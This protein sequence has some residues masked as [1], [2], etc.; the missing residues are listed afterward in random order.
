MNATPIPPSTPQPERRLRSVCVFCG[1]AEGR[2]SVYREA[3]REFGRLLAREGMALVFGGGR[4][5]LMGVVAD[6]ALGAGGEAIG[7]IPRMLVEREIA[8]TG[9]TELH[10]VDS[11]FERKEKMAELSDAFVLLPGGY[12]SLDEFTEALTWAQLGLSHKP[13][14]VLNVNGYYNRLLG[15]FDD[16]AREGFVPPAFRALVVAAAEPEALLER[17]RTAP[18]VSEARWMGDSRR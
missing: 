2:H 1:A 9:L 14:G 10:V 6:A 16:A 4:V 7:V 3:A 13:C 8:H 11:M 17:L 12:G 5:G 15:W 18:V